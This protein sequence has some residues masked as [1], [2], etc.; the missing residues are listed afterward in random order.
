MF[1]TIGHDDIVS[2]MHCVLKVVRIQ[3]RDLVLLEEVLSPFETRYGVALKSWMLGQSDTCV[4]DFCSE[5]QIH[6]RR[7]TDWMRSASHDIRLED[8][9]RKLY[10]KESLSRIKPR[11]CA[12]LESAI[13]SSFVF[14]SLLDGMQYDVIIENGRVKKILHAVYVNKHGKVP[15]M[16]LNHMFESVP[17]SD[18]FAFIRRWSKPEMTWDTLQD[19]SDSIKNK[20][21][22]MNLY[23]IGYILEHVAY[24]KTPVYDDLKSFSDMLKRF[25][26]SQNMLDAIVDCK[27]LGIECNMEHQQALQWLRTRYWS[28]MCSYPYK[29]YDLL[30][31]VIEWGWMVKERNHVTFT[32]VRRC[33]DEIKSVLKD[34]EFVLGDPDVI[35]TSQNCVLVS[36]EETKFEFQCR[37]DNQYKNIYVVSNPLT[38]KKR[39]VLIY[40]AHHLRIRDWM[41]ILPFLKKKRSIHIM[42]RIDQYGHLFTDMLTHHPYVERPLST[43]CSYEYIHDVDDIKSFRIKPSMHC[44]YMA[45]KSIPT[46]LDPQRIW[47]FYPKR[48]RTVKKIAR[49]NTFKFY[50]S[51][52]E[53]S[54]TVVRNV[55]DAS[56]IAVRDYVGPT[57]ATI[58]MIVDQDTKPFDLYTVRTLAYDKVYYL[59]RGTYCAREEKQQPRRSLIY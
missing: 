44:Q 26:K 56:I 18:R 29:Q 17:R 2:R 19:T 15:R 34:A 42:G 27:H 32:F 24:A 10:N 14:P 36:N 41:N 55:H 54:N 11:N 21:M 46:V 48:I 40:R 57:L 13:W 1:Y 58:V 16:F 45:S 30:D 43:C 31:R 38:T 28:L 7:L 22:D 50:E 5:C 33:V 52:L 4:R 59:V 49:D 35:E 37:T 6:R 9:V 23:T 3:R 25:W 8:A 53:S 39:D 20:Q 51:D 47:L 12:H